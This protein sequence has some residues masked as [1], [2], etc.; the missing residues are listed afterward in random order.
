MRRDS[1]KGGEA[2]IPVI[3]RAHCVKRWS[4]PDSGVFICTINF[5]TPATVVPR[6]LLPTIQIADND[7]FHRRSF[8]CFSRN[9]NLLTIDL[10]V[11]NC[12]TTR[13]TD[14]PINKRLIIRT[15]RSLTHGANV[16]SF[17][18]DQLQHLSPTLWVLGH[19]LN[20]TRRIDAFKTNASFQGKS[21]D[22]IL[23]QASW[24]CTIV[25]QTKRVGLRLANE[26]C[27]Q[28][29]CNQKFYCF[30]NQ[31]TPPHNIETSH[32]NHDIGDRYERR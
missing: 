1:V 20:I 26:Q 29:R 8:L 10:E 9:R 28:P 18:G 27:A 31:L 19:K 11:R 30:S 3:E 12:R 23:N 16:Y 21:R 13:I 7:D 2:Q 14:E 17:A 6:Q 5:M 4:V 15:L 24:Y 22:D 25:R 32:C